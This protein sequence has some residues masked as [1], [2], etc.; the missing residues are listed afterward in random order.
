MFAPPFFRSDVFVVSPAIVSV[1]A[2]PG[3]IVFDV[4]VWA[5]CTGH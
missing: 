4:S 2:V 3:G 1:A 5:L